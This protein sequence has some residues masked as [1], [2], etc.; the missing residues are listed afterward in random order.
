MFS[1]HD[2]FIP[3]QKSCA[4]IILTDPFDFFLFLFYIY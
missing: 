2:F 3:L 1:P 4:K